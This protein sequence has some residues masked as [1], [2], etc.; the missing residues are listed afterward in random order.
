MK[1]GL[2]LK[3]LRLIIGNS[4]GGMQAW[5]W[6][7]KHPEMMDAL[8]PMA[9]QPTEMAARN[10]MM[11]RLLVETIRND[12]E[13]NN[14]DYTKQPRSMKI[15]NTMY[16]VGTNG[17]TLA[18]QKAAPTSAAADKFVDDRLAAPFNPD[19]NDYLYAWESSRGYNPAPGLEK[20]Q[21]AVLAINSAD[22]ER[23][24]PET[25]V[26]EAAMKRIKNARMLL[27]PASEETRGHGTTAFAKFY[28]KELREFLDKVPQRG[29]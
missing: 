18:F 3:N 8:V 20:I 6:G 24:P 4:M 25:G 22:D 11:R 2:G 9:S 7:V 19:A 12:P 29:M 13:Y 28:A 14:G 5:M 10:W 26:T 1:E 17:G 27:I 21:A 23:N 16:A 15:A